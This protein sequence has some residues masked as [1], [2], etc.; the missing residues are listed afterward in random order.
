[1]KKSLQTTSLTGLSNSPPLAPHSPLT[2][3]QSAHNPG[4]VARI[5]DETSNGDSPLLHL[6]SLPTYSETNYCFRNTPHLRLP[7]GPSRPSANYPLSCQRRLQSIS[8]LTNPTATESPAPVPPSSSRLRCWKTEQRKVFLDTYL[9][10]WQCQFAHCH[11]FCFGLGQHHINFFNAVTQVF[12][13]FF[14][15]FGGRE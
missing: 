4:T 9:S 5:A 13:C 15:F 6:S 2:P 3:S 7:A 1:M 12:V 11:F 8:L 14:V 10:C